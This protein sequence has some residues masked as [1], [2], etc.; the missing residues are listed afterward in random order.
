VTPLAGVR[1]LDFCWVLAGPLGT[2]IL[3]NHGAEVIHVE[4]R[5]GDPDFLPRAARDPAVGAFRNLTDTGKRSITVDPRSEAGREA[6]LALAAISDLVVDNFRPGVM[7][8]MGFGYARLRERNPR[9]IALH[10]PGCSP[11]GPWGERGTFGNMILG[12]SGLSVLSRFPGRPPRGCGVAF[13]DFTSPYLL[14]AACLAALRERDASGR[15]QEIWLDQLSATTALV[16]VEWMQFHATGVEPAPR[17]NR[18]P[19]YAPHGVYPAR[20]D[21]QWCALAVFGDAEWPAFC[22]AIGRSDLAA[23]PRF[24]THALRKANEDALDALVSA[25]TRLRDKWEIADA[26]QAAGIAAAAV[27]DVSDM[28][29]RDPHTAACYPRFRHPTSPDV[30]VASVAEA[31]RFVGDERALAPAPAPG[32][33]DR[34]VLRDLLGGSESDFDKARRVRL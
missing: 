8:R 11:A 19:N 10:L 23:D 7:E 1:V 30:E 5:A 14:V 32:E 24:A 28:L 29:E 20:G 4:P 12:A 31:I 18:D 17:A 33:A 9:A 25:W 21:D 26:L 15:G 6:L 16:G 13:A 27:E 34:Y 3:A 22:A 2:R